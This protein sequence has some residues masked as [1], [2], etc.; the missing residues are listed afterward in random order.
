MERI[1][2]TYMFDDRNG[3]E[4]MV[5]AS[6]KDKDDEGI[7]CGEVCSMFMEFMR[8]AGFSESN[9]LNYFNT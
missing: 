7:Q 4:H 3:E 1:N 5:T 9:I 6:K 2:F 8:S